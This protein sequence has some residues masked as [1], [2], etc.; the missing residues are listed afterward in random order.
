MSLKPASVAT[1]LELRLK[2]SFV[3]LFEYRL[4]TEVHC[5]HYIKIYWMFKHWIIFILLKDMI[6]LD[7]FN[8]A[9]I[10]QGG[11]SKKAEKGNSFG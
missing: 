5:V 1:H 7:S 10:K 8:F 9:L 3:G 11:F 4:D 2:M 6:L